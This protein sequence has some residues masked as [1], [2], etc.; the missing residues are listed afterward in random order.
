[1]TVKTFE[2]VSVN[3]DREL[4]V[5]VNADDECQGEVDTAESTTRSTGKQ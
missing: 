1:M 5:S 2:S 4:F 3:H